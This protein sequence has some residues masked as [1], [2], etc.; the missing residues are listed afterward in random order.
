LS[1]HGFEIGIDPVRRDVRVTTRNE[2]DR[3]TKLPRLAGFENVVTVEIG[4]VVNA[5]GETGRVELF[6]QRVAGES[7][8]S[9]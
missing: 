4:A 6:D 2:T 7:V 8:N 3:E 9:A 1:D 5:E